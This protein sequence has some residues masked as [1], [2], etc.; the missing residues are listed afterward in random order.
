MKVESRSNDPEPLLWQ[1]GDIRANDNRQPRITRL[2]ISTFVSSKLPSE[3]ESQDG[4]ETEDGKEAED[5]PTPGRHLET[6]M[7][8][9]RQQELG[10]ATGQYCQA[11]G[12]IG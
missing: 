11:L 4:E 9:I 7:H 3:E 12:T 8:I 6:F 2:A 5:D 10:F 1:R